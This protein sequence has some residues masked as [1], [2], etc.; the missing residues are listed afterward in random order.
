MNEG[1]EI[2]AGFRD[3]SGK[4]PE[5]RDERA[6]ARTGTLLFAVVSAL[7][8][9]DVVADVAEGA[10]AAH[11]GAEGAAALLALFGTALFATRLFG[12][13]RKLRTER[14][15]LAV[16]GARLRDRADAL[17]SALTATRAEAERFREE[18]RE[19]TAGLGAA[20][21]R[22]LERWQLTTAERE[23]A[24]LLLKGLSHGEIASVRDVSERTVRQQAQAVYKKAGLAGRAELSA[25]FLEDLLAPG[26]DSATRS[27]QAASR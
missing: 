6:L 18:V 2:S 4:R 9:A 17:G 24:W 5:R 27:G 8:A 23:V 26:L 12:L 13:T 25:F 16:E 22:Q 7:V 15:R 10:G 21:D 20:I 11:V 19:L 3:G 14:E 1:P